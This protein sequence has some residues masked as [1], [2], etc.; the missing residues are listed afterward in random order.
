MLC[1]HR[2]T[3][4]SR[5]YSCATRSLAGQ[6]KHEN[7]C[8]RG[9]V[10]SRPSPAARIIYAVVYGHLWLL[11]YIWWAEAILGL[12][13]N[14]ATCQDRRQRSRTT[15]YAKLWSVCDLAD[16]TRDEFCKCDRATK[17]PEYIEITPTKTYGI[18]GI[19]HQ[20]VDGTTKLGG[21]V[22]PK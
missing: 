16:N 7:G 9:N 2:G 17:P 21:V 14:L 8:S 6:G 18:H 10:C 5:V 15:L 11:H 1:V 20:N 12:L 3:R 19:P 13:H 22:L 4:S